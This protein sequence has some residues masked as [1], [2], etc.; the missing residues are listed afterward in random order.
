MK[1]ENLDLQAIG[2]QAACDTLPQALW[3]NL[4]TNA[5]LKQMVIHRLTKKI[6]KL[7]KT[8]YARLGMWVQMK[9]DPIHSNPFS[10][11]ALQMLSFLSGY[12][13]SFLGEMMRVMESSKC[14]PGI[15]RS[16]TVP[17]SSSS[18]RSESWDGFWSVLS[19]DV[20]LQWS[21]GSL[22]SKLS[23]M[24]VSLRGMRAVELAGA[25]VSHILFSFLLNNHI[26]IM[27]QEAVIDHGNITGIPLL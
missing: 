5:L 25:P 3:H 4:V 22:A 10:Y 20:W 13:S 26:W 11:A 27:L 17:S 1:F 15:E 14:L 16:V 8:C 24:G 19:S 9:P 12:K 7:I 2:Q 18:S 21:S 23:C 6:H